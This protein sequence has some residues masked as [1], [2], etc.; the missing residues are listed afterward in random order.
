MR[1]EELPNNIIENINMLWEKGY[2]WVALDNKI[3]PIEEYVKKHFSDRR[4]C[5]CMG[6]PD[7][8]E[9]ICLWRF[10]Q[11]YLEAPYLTISR[12]LTAKQKRKYR[13]QCKMIPTDGDG[14]RK[15]QNPSP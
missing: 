2:L 11:S 12:S 3:F 5:F 13:C 6:N 15:I 7:E 9:E 14:R 4:I 8:G 1:E 10:R